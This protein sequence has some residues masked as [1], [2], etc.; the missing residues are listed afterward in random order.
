MP[1]FM[2]KAREPI[3]SY[4]HFLGAILFGSGA[5]LLFLKALAGGDA[6]GRTLLSLLAF[7]CSITALYSA[8]A[9][10]HFSNRAPKVIH[11]LR[12]TG[13]FHDLRFDCRHLYANSADLF[14]SA[15]GDRLYCRHVDHRRRRH[16]DEAVLV[17]CSSLVVHFPVPVDG[18]GHSGGCIHLLPHELRRIMVARFRRHLLYC[19]RCN[20][21][22]KKTKYFC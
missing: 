5:I 14:G 6:S 2:K 1:Y 22:D 3:S 21:W 19:R 10:Y 20:L 13:S 8:S 15:Q 18:L 7:G 17:P 9:I 16:P 4:T 12:K 11:H